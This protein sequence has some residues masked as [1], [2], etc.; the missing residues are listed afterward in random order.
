ML[1][2]NQV[3]YCQVARKVQN[4]EVEVIPGIAYYGKVFV[5]GETFPITQKTR[6]IEYSRQRFTE[7]QEQVYILIVEDQDR[8]TLWYENSEVTRLA[9]ENSE[10]FSDFISS[11]DLKQLV[12]QMRSSSNLVTKTKRRGF[13]TFRDC[14]SARD[15]I[16]WLEYNL[17]ISR[18]DAIRLGQRLLQENWIVPLTN[19]SLSFQE[20]DALYNFETS[21]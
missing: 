18:A 16:N 15:A 5:R 20:G 4:G 3:R 17:Q 6:A 10:Y 8:L 21:V 11:I 1:S 12:T 14:F 13:R 7:Y 2:A 19:N 9:S